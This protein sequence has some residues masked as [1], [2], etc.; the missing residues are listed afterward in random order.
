MLNTLANR[1]MG[2]I[3]G[4]IRQLVDSHD[5]LSDNQIERLDRLDRAHKFWRRLAN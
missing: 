3:D 1:R 4:R 5:K 2:E